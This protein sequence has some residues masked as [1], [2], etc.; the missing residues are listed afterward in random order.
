[1]YLTFDI[2]AATAKTRFAMPDP[3]DPGSGPDGG[4]GVDGGGN[5]NSGGG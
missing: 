3:E 2:H 4:G 5:G 1:M